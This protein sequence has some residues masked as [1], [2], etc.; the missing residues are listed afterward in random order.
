M[1]KTMFL[2]TIFWKLL[3]L[4]AHFCKK[5]WRRQKSLV[6]RVG[7]KFS[8]AWNE[9]IVVKWFISNF[10]WGNAKWK[11]VSCPHYLKIWMKWSKHGISYRLKHD[12]MSISKITFYANLSVSPKYW[13]QALISSKN[14][15]IFTKLKHY[16][17]KPSYWPH[18]GQGI[19]DLNNKQ[20]FFWKIIKA[21]YQ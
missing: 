5:L 10:F 8:D 2:L 16:S 4:G 20:H 18:S 15:S 19:A 14:C 17:T 6:Y 21:L 1:K 13:Y 12:P 3:S 9:L 7:H 11:K